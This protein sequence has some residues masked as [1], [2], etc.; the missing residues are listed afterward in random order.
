MRQFL[1]FP[2]LFVAAFVAAQEPAPKVTEAARLVEKLGSQ[3][4]EEREAASKRLEELGATALE[5]LRVGVKS[6]NPET[7]RRAQDLLRK[8]ERRLS[9]DKVLAP[10]LVELDVKDQPLDAVLAELSKQAKWEVVLGGLKPEDLAVKKL[11]VS[12]GGKVAFWVAV[13]KLCDVAEMQIAGVSGFVAPG[14]MPYLGRA[15]PGVRIAADR[16]RAVVLEARGDSPR[17]PASVNG[18][19]LIEAVPFPKNVLPLA[20]AHPSALLQ[21]WPEPRLQWEGTAATKVTRATDASGAKLAAEFTPIPTGDIRATGTGTVL[22]RNA[23]GSVTVVKDTGSAFEL[24]GGFRPNPRQAVIQFKPIEKSVNTAKELGVSMFATVRTGIEPLCQVRDLESGKAATGSAP[25]GVDI[26]V[27]YATDSRGK[28]VASVHLSYDMKAIHAATVDDTLP[29]MRGGA[30]GYGNHTVYGIRVADAD[31]KPY[32]LGLGSGS[33]QIDPTN[34]RILLKLDL[35]LHRDKDGQGPP[36][37]IAFWGTHAKSVE[38]PV[39]LKDVPLAGG[40]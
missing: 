23:D 13:L 4:F 28:L 7:A 22:I 35:E 32:M 36:A 37:S 33:N 38:L 12:T 3:D 39:L 19:V 2:A 17:R 11:T 5:E 26:S 10:T 18:A 16:N 25:S 34:K 1:V 20:T 29:G 9:N 31:G 8:V 14:A 6:E 30:A 40:R 24:P 27:T 15:K 21:A